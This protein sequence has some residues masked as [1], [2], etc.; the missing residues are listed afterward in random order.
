M[1]LIDLFRI[2]ICAWKLYRETLIYSSNLKENRLILQINFF[3]VQWL[4]ILLAHLYTTILFFLYTRTIGEINQVW[5]LLC[6][7]V[8]LVY[9]L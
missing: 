6:S 2:K 7:L 3:E 4:Q 1:I 8:L 9:M 5:L